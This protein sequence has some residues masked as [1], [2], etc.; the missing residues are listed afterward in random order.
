MI[1]FNGI[2]ILL[3]R[4][5]GADQIRQG[6][7]AVLSVEPC[8]V[9]VIDDVADYPERGSADVVSV[10]TPTSGEFAAVVSIQCEPMTL[11]FVNVWE[12]VEQ[13]SAVLEAKVLVPSDGPDPYLMWLVQPDLPRRLVSLDA[14]A[15]EDDR[16]EIHSIG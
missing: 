2:D 10:V 6:V 16:Y 8:R 4:R 14:D 15:L 5:L 13:L 3:D 12:V 9:S 11:P 7:A 1:E